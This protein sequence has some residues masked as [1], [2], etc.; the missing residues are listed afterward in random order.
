MRITVFIGAVFSIVLTAFAAAFL[1]VTADLKSEFAALRM[2]VAALKRASVSNVA[3]GGSRAQGAA[4][5]RGWAVRIYQVP[6]RRAEKPGEDSFAGSFVHTGSWIALDEYKKHEG[7]FLSGNAEL[8]MQGQFT[9]EMSGD[10]VFAVHM[11]VTNKEGEQKQDVPT[12]S[13]YARVGDQNRVEILKGK[14]LVDRTR[15]KGALISAA[16]VF[17]GKEA[18]R[19]LNVSFKC[20][21]MPKLDS[22]RILFRICFRKAEEASFKPLV[23]TLKI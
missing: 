13:C 19:L 4:N 17:V 9:P 6:Q 14:M 21:G 23:P 12:V 5:I 1:S 16:P 20:N 22:G 15:T 8:R 2:E 18:P 11:K 10:Y 3:Y 7:I